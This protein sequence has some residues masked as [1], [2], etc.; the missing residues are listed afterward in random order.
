MEDKIV[1]GIDLGT[2]FSSIARVNQQGDAVCVNLGEEG[3]WAIPSSVL[4]DGRKVFVG[5]E[6]IENCWKTDTRLIEF[7][8]RSIGL[9]KAPGWPVNY[10]GWSYSEEEI[11]ALILR[12]VA[13]QV[14]LQRTLLPVQDVVITHPQWFYLGQKEAT[15]E[16]ADLAGLNLIGTITEPH[17]AAIAYGVYEKASTGRELTVMVFDLGGGT[18]DTCLMKLGPTRFEMLGSSGDAQLGGMNWDA[19]IINRAK[20]IFLEATGDDFDSVYVEEENIALRKAAERAKKKLSEN[21]EIGFWIAAGGARTRAEIKREEFE[22]WS[23]PLVMRCLQK[24]DDLLQQASFSWKDIDEILMVG[25]STRMPMI[26]E[27]VRR[28]SGKEPLIDKDPKLMVAKGAAIWGH[29]IQTGKIDP[30]RTAGIEADTSGLSDLETPTVVGRTAHGLGIL[31]TREKRSGADQET[32]ES[33]VTIL[34]P[35]NTTTPYNFEKTFYTNRDNETSI[36]VPLYEGESEDPKECS[37]IG[38]VTLDGLPPRPRH[39]PV[40]VKFNIDTSGLLE[41]EMTDLGTGH[42]EIKRLDKN[43]LSNQNPGTGKETDPV[44]RRR[45]LEELDV[46]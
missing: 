12:K 4:L 5:Q 27:A 19:L 36:S 3:E 25:S 39:Q 21:E 6:A 22:E 15:R 10:D 37:R 35:Q 7:A 17:A 16:A 45:H 14:A 32:L 43:I 41:V 18:F 38:Q 20:E 46:V 2:T 30:R 9:L 8:K 23:R 28:A 11:S 34:I 26:R 33:V 44:S 13:K 29:W 31:A 24:C 42:K 1:Y 40:N